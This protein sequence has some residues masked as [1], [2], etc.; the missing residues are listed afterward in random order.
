MPSFS[1]PIYL[2]D[3]WLVQG[4]GGHVMWYSKH[5]GPYLLQVQPHLKLFVCILLIT[6]NATS[7]FYLVSFLVHVPLLHASSLLKGVIYCTYFNCMA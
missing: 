1:A 7:D 5:C 2:I 6:Q 3:W 4:Q